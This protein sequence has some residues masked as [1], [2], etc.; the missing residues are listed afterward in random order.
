MVSSSSRRAIWL[1]IPPSALCTLVSLILYVG[2]RLHTLLAAQKAVNNGTPLAQAKRPQSLQLAWIFF[3]A[4]LSTLV[5]DAFPFVLRLVAFRLPSRITDALTGDDVPTIDIFITCCREDL[6]VIMDTT[7]AA[8][9]LDYPRDRCRVFVCDDGPSTE[10]R[11]AV[12]ALQETYPN[13]YYTARVKDPRV[14]D[15]KAGNLNHALTHS[16][17]LPRPPSRSSE[18]IA[19]LDADMI[20]EP[21]WLRTM[22]PYMVASSKIALACPPQT[23]YDIPANDP[24]T[25]T[26]DHFAGITELINDAVDHADCLGSGYVARRVAIEG[27][28]GFPI[29]SLSED[30]CCSAMLL[31]AGWKTAFV[32]SP[33]QHGSVPDSFVAH[34]KQRTRW[35][36]GHVQTALLFRFR[37]F[38]SRGRQLTP[39]QRLAGIVFDLRQVAQIPLALNYLLVPLSLF[40]GYPLIVWT[41]DYELQWLIRLVVLWMFCHWLHEGVLGVIFALGR[42]VRLTSLDIFM[43]WLQSFVLP[44]RLG[45][46]RAGFTASGTVRSDIKERDAHERAPLLRR[47]RVTLLNHWVYIHVLL[48][49]ACLAGVSLS[50]TRAFARNP[51]PSMFAMR[52]LH[53]STDRLVYLVTRIGWPPFAWLQYCMSALAPVMYMFFPPTAKDRET[54][55]DRDEKTQVAYPRQNAR[56]AERNMGGAWRY[57]RATVAIIFTLALLV[58]SEVLL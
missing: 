42:D 6:D 10:V 52:P 8:C 49:T 30:V 13:V 34:I 28:G 33:L 44:T 54:L 19:G 38:G 21:H 14:K 12:E 9:V 7:R 41:E 18:F 47:L 17:Q 51:L 22:M 57:A 58:L 23:F 43:A 45:G 50:V 11:A 32:E 48:I 1:L 26:M 46:V 4:E 40:S 24:L 37:L 35:F 2:Y 3:V 16:R 29:E 31:G 36:V 56:V 39:A 55:L 5:P 25:Q 53:S 20:P 27:I 15:Y